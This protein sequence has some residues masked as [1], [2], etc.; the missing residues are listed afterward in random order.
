M[1]A[2]QTPYFRKRKRPGMRESDPKAPEDP[3]ASSARATIMSPESP[4]ATKQRAN[5][6]TRASNAE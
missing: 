1:S 6:A 2:A 4:A 5:P 3:P